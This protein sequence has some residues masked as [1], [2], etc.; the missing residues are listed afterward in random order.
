MEERVPLPAGGR[1]QLLAAK[2]GGT[3]VLPDWPVAPGE[4]ATVILRRYEVYAP[5]ARVFA[6]TPNGTVEV[7]R[8]PR[9]YFWGT[10]A[11]DPDVRV[12]VS[13]DPSTGEMGGSVF[14]EAG[15]YSIIPDPLDPERAVL[16][17]DRRTLEE[18][19]ITPL[20]SCGA[21][22]LGQPIPIEALYAD[23]LEPEYALPSLHTAT[24]AVD[25]DTEFMSLKF[26]N[27]TTNATAYIANLVAAMNVMYER[28]LN[29]RLL[30]GTTYL[31]VSTDPYTAQP[32]LLD[33][34][35]PCSD[36]ANGAQLAEFKNYW[37]ANY[38]SVSRALA[39]L[40]SGK[41]HCNN[42]S[43]GVSY[44]DQLCSKSAGYSFTQVFKINYLAGD[45]KVVGH[46]LGHG[47]GSPHTHC[48]TPPLDQCYKQTGCYQGTSTSCP[49]PQTINGVPNVRGTIMSYCQFVPSCT[50]SLVFHPT[51]VALLDP[52][53]THEI[54]DCVFP[55]T[56]PD[57]TPPEISNA[58]VQPASGTAGTSFLIS[59]DVTDTSGVAS[60]SASVR[61][62]ADA[63]IDTVTMALSSGSTYTGAF[64][65][66]GVAAA[67]YSVDIVATDASTNA[68]QG[69]AADAATFTVQEP[70]ICDLVLANQAV[71]T[72]Q[73]WEACNS[74]TAGPNFAVTSPGHASMRAATRIVLRNGFRVGS[75][76]TFTA[77]IDPTLGT[78]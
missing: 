48:Y 53:V 38:G 59:A 16:R 46:E 8:S 71:N 3:L 23:S 29:V 33:P 20:W 15:E 67:T 77:G 43:S 44:L 28:D 74:I 37:A 12:I 65:S 52:L 49:N 47:F 72:T 9:T 19:G 68:N 75:G 40:L 35:D 32:D 6:V 64:D 34:N 70:V 41:Q 78:S 22:Q 60:V 7:S 69:T 21:D 10:A 50:V 62:L 76:A 36:A 24:I 14:S 4:F 42:Y 2:D 63:L 27:N 13:V 26:S 51:T 25:T 66:T 55:F 57:T 5:G 17:D 30:V 56:P 39:I 58:S 1:E 18:L 73:A 54:G 61:T 45:A 31:R 11:S